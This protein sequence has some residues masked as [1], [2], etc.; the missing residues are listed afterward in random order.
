MV[1]ISI[2]DHKQIFIHVYRHTLCSFNRHASY[3][4]RSLTTHLDETTERREGVQDEKL[5]EE[6]NLRRKPR[7][8]PLG[9]CDPPP[10]PEPIEPTEICLD[11]HLWLGRGFS[12]T[13]SLWKGKATFFKFN[14]KDVYKFRRFRLSLRKMVVLGIFTNINSYL[15]YPVELRWSPPPPPLPGNFYLLD[16]LIECIWILIN[17]FHIHDLSILVIKKAHKGKK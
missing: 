17:I 6:F 7:L 3:N 4:I 8:F 14:A 16:Y 11:L 13:F 2:N 9:T 15:N 10:P 5:R 1:D 12:Q